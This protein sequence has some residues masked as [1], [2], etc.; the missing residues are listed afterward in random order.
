MAYK[1]IKT[2]FPKFLKIIMPRRLR[3]AQAYLDHRI[4]EDS[5]MFAPKKEN[6]LRQSGID[7]TV[8]GDGKIIWKTPYAHYQYEGRAMVGVKSKS[9]YAHEKEPKEYNGKSLNYHTPGTG[10]HW[11]ETA[12]AKCK[13]TWRKGLIKILI[14]GKR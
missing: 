8:L 4:M 9:A 3:K 1:N 11:F 7:N 13:E 2:N 14:A 12:K 10:D 6:A 5:N